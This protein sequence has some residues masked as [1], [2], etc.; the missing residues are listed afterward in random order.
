MWSL[1]HNAF[2]LRQYKWVITHENIQLPLKEGCP[3]HGEDPSFRKLWSYLCPGRPLLF[4]TAHVRLWSFINTHTIKK[5][6]NSHMT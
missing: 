1:Y 6:K 2:T 3:S 4:S 5:K